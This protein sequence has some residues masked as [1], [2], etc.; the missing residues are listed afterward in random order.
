[1]ADEAN[2]K[3][4]NKLLREKRCEV[5]RGLGQYV[6]QPTFV[7]GSVLCQAPSSTDWTRLRTALA[8]EGHPFILSSCCPARGGSDLRRGNPRSGVERSRWTCCRSG[9]HSHKQRRE[10]TCESHHGRRRF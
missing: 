2:S 8:H 6:A 3:R 9:R 4:F 5:Q 7:A 10:A 1:M